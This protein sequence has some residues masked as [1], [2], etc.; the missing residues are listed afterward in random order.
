[1]LKAGTSLVDISPERGVQLAG[2]PH[3]PRPNRGVHDPLYAAALYLD[4]GKSRKVFV[5]LDLLSIGK[6][7]V[8]N[9]R[10]K[11][12][13]LYITVSTTHTHS[14]PWA[15]EPLAS[16]LAEGIDRNPAYMAFLEERMEAAV[17]EAI[18]APFDAEFGTEVGRCGAE[19]CVRW[20]DDG[21]Q[22]FR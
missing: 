19:P 3:C 4:N 7:E 10:S 21:Q 9:L 6:E 2:Y 18:A 5:T 8:G 11:F 15:S 20:H 12:P 16:E 13:E 22:R 14:G 1:M 17:R